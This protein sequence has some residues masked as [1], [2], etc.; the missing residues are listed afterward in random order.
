MGRR[1]ETI[2]NAQEAGAIGAALVVAAGIK[3]EDVLELARRLV[4]ANRV[5]VPDTNNKEV[6]ERN[7]R[8]FK[9]LYKSNAANFKQLN[10]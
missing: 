2:S 5:Y 9:K 10:P 1:I 4:K 7:Y 6:Y 8:V 3:G